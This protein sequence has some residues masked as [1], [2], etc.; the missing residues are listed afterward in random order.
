MAL[1]YAPN[2]KKRNDIGERGDKEPGEGDVSGAG[3]PGPL[4]GGRSR[5]EG[6]RIWGHWRTGHKTTIRLKV[7][8]VPKAVT[9]PGRDASKF[10]WG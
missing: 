10:T 6:K 1:K 9:E 4:S 7:T 8:C 5:A 3:V 2:K